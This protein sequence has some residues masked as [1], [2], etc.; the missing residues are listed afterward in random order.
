MVVEDCEEGTEVEGVVILRSLV[1][2]VAGAGRGAL[3]GGGEAVP[4]FVH[5]CDEDEDGAAADGAH[6][7]GLVE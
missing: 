6:E 3:E 4:P 1:Y 7:D 2:G 5:I